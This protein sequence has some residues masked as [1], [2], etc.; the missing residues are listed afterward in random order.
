MRRVKVLPA[1]YAVPDQSIT[2]FC[3][4]LIGLSRET[5][6]RPA[7]RTVERPRQNQVGQTPSGGRGAARQRVHPEVH[8]E[9][10]HILA[11]QHRKLDEE[12]RNK[13]TEAMKSYG[14]FGTFA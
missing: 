11:C 8:R 7:C 5:G 6:F 4:L 1:Y 14:R 12:A 9:A 13:E 10:L 2:A 3:N